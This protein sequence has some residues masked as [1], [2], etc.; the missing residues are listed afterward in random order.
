M[1]I[2]VEQV[3]KVRACTGATYEQARSALL[4][5]GGNVLDAVILLE[6]QGA[7]AGEADYSTRGGAGWASDSPHTPTREEIRQALRDL[8]SH[9]LSI[10]L[11]IWK[12]DHITSTIPLIILLILLI[13]SPAAVALVVVIGLCTGYKVHVTGPGTEG[14]RGWVN[15]WLDQLADTLNDAVVQA[16][17]EYRR[18]EKEKKNTQKK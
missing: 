10:V 1:D 4:E 14:W 5:T 18:R 16:R 8:L 2:T 3:D 15:G 17:R 12:G 13:V 6:R 7:A 11:E 9:F